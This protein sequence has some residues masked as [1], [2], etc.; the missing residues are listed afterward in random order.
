MRRPP[1][2]KITLAKRETSAGDTGFQ[3]D[4]QGLFAMGGV[5]GL[6]RAERF[7]PAGLTTARIADGL[8]LQT[9]VLD[10]VHDLQQHKRNDRLR[11]K[12]A[13]ILIAACAGK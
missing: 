2:S 7:R 1:G 4:G 12:T 5:P 10:V 9:A 3:R 11:R 8:A 6:H 13:T